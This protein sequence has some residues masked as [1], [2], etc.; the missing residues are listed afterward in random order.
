MTSGRNIS[1]T[2][3]AIASF[4]STAFVASLW[5]VSMM[6]SS[7]TEV[8]TAPG[9][10]EVVQPEVT[11]LEFAEAEVAEPAQAVDYT[12]FRHGNQYHSRLPCLVCHVRNDNSARVRFPGRNNHLP[13]SGCHA[14]QFSDPASPICTICHTNAQSGAMKQFPGL[15]SFGA[16]FNHSRHA[17]VNC[18][19]CHSPA[20]RG[21]AR[22]I[23]SGRAAH[24]TCFQCHT[25]NASNAMASC[26]TCHQPG[27]LVRVSESARAFRMNFSHA[28]HSAN[29]DLSC[30][31]C[32]TVRA[33]A[34]RG[35][36]VSSP[37][38]SMHFAPSQAQ[39][40]A[41]CHNNKR[42]FGEDFANCK[43]CHQGN[44][45]RF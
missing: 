30:R 9:D 45:F 32:H 33:G 15:R 3:K 44:V 4:L 42:A 23:P 6:G 26:G 13:C 25:A 5:C 40:C 28:R 43:R 7:L 22:D 12:R 39:S 1:T 34:A 2:G 24:T 20:A 35:R 11:V 8:V 27:R 19:T 14:L 38:A 31:S 18:T 10:P 29:R 41:S 21:V 36:Q 16:R 37:L 17:R